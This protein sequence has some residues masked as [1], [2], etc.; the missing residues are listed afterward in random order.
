[1]Y[2]IVNLNPS[3]IV[4]TT[5]FPVVGADVH[6]PSPVREGLTIALALD[7]SGS[8]SRKELKKGASQ[9]KAIT[10]QIPGSTLHVIEHDAEVQKTYT[11]GL[12]GERRQPDLEMMGRGGTDHRPV[13]TH[14][15]EE[16]L[17]TEIDALITFTDGGTRFPDKKTVI[18]LGE[19]SPSKSC[20][21]FGGG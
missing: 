8:M 14:I 9:A 2:V 12:N 16:N 19:K 11:L 5:G 4:Q 21:G 3:V 15:E 6:L 10:D 7:T 20:Q 13:F 18:L 17:D 1:M